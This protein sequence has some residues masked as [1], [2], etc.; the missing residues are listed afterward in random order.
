MREV[1]EPVLSVAEG[2]PAMPVGR[3][4]SKLS[5]HE[6]QAKSKKSQARIGAE[7]L[8]FLRTI[9]GNVF[10]ERS[11]PTYGCSDLCAGVRM[12]EPCSAAGM[13][14]AGAVSY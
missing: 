8:Q 12:D 2:T 3:C 7:D 11:A 13:N 14:E 4:S 6:P 1:E 10:E 5:G 9:P